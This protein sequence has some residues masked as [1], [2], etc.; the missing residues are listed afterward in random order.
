MMILRMLTVD[1]HGGNRTCIIC[2]EAMLNP[3][4]LMLHNRM[5]L[6]I[7]QTNNTLH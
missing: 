4:H 5:L 3:E 2:V 1:L 7:I 6:S